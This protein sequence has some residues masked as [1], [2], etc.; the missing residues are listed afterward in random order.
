M[1]VN[2]ISRDKDFI[3]NVIDLE[4]LFTFKD[5]PVFMGCTEK[6]VDQVI[7]GLKN[8]AIILKAGSY[9]NEI[10]NDIQSNINKNVIYFE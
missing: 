2:K 5:F 7:K 8:V 3:Y 6:S 9:N 4:H 10:K 1:S